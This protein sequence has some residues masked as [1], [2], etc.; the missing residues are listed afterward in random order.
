MKI[1]KY[2]DYNEYKDA[3]ARANRRKLNWVW[4]G[5]N[6]IKSIS[7]YL[8]K[9]LPSALFGIC[10]G[11]RNSMEVKWFREFLG[12][13]VI[14]TDI[15]ETAK[16]FL[17][18]I[19]WDFHEVKDEW[20]GSVDFIYSNSLDHSYDP[21]MCI[22]QWMK[23]IKND[24][25]CFIEWT[26]EHIP[27]NSTDP[28]GGTRRNYM[29]LIKKK[30]QIQDVLIINSKLLDKDEEELKKNDFIRVSRHLDRHIFVIKHRKT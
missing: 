13:E 14:G 1:Y 22:D 27:S 3:Q 2:S 23:C 18:T 9:N 6:E 25:F 12:I 5:K 4:A 15:S 10:H 21:E 19:Q 20:I 8:K 29:N 24:A 30:Y 11:S 17:H 16:N 7:E 28:F 26:R